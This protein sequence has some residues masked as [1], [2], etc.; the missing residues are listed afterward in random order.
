[1]GT[2]GDH[3]MA[4]NPRDRAARIA[5]HLTPCCARMESDSMGSL[6]IPDDKYYGCQTKRSTINFDIGGPAENMPLPI[7]HAF[8]ALKHAAAIV[9]VRFGLDPSISA[10]I[11]K[12]AE[13][14]ATGQL[15]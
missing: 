6:E 2:G 7:I 10:N 9:N 5:A 8:G 1:M 3:S 11:V 15:D 13:E 12:A 4:T 14:V